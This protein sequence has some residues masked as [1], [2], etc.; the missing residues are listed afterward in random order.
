MLNGIVNCQIKD[1]VHSTGSFLRLSN[2]IK[3]E[4]SQMLQNK[5]VLIHP[6]AGWFGSW[7]IT[8]LSAETPSRENKMNGKDFLNQVL[9][10][11]R[12]SGKKESNFSLFLTDFFTRTGQ[13][14]D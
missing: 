3:S 7:L 11:V 2:I 14:Q 12:S 5:V 10:C 4:I 8:E 1:K 13:L 9:V 6:R